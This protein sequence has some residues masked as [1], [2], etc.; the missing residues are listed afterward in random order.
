MEQGLVELSENTFGKG[1]KISH[2]HVLSY[3]VLLPH[4][5]VKGIIPAVVF[6]FPTCTA[7][8]CLSTTRARPLSL[9]Y[10]VASFIAEREREKAILQSHYLLA[11]LA[12]FSIF[13][14][15]VWR[16]TTSELGRRK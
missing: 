6:F 8:A 10:L 1:K 11:R 9:P 2:S 4:L 7:S 13:F 5:P 16:S 3:F 12:S 15:F 14:S